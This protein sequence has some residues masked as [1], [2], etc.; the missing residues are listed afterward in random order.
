MNS[1]R[2][3][4]TSFVRVTASAAG[5]VALILV[6][7]TFVTAAA[8]AQE[9]AT[10]THTDP[11]GT[12]R[13]EHDENGETV[14][15]VLKL[16]YDSKAN[17]VTGSYKGR[18]GP[19]KVENG[20]MDGDKLKFRLVIELDGNE[21]VID[22]NGAIKGDH[23]NGSVTIE[24][25][26]QSGDLPWTAKRSLMAEDVVGTWNLKLQ[27]PDGN[28]LTPTVR[29]S[30]DGDKLKGDYTGLNGRF[31]AQAT[32]VSVKDGTLKFT[33]GGERDGNSLTADYT[34]TPR[35]DSLTGKI[36]YDING[37]TGELDVTGTREADKE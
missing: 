7:L 27:S 2:K 35:G 13:W 22:F 10:K 19:I 4:L 23:A 36:A 3:I 17:K 30:L 32:A 28:T 15:D 12:W 29:F 21:I 37:Q 20:T 11:S 33:V 5:L 24:V 26:G 9:T 1:A 31:Q 8:V 25:N 18:V 16:N 14:K 6:A 34:V